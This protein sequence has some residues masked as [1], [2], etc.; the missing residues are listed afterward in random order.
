MKKITTNKQKVLESVTK[1]VTDKNVVQSFLKGKI[2]AEALKQ[3]GITL[4]NPL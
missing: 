4:A 3:K 1:M 2:N